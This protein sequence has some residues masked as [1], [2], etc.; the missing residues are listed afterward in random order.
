MENVNYGYNEIQPVVPINKGGR[1]SANK[2]NN[3]KKKA[4]AYNLYC[5]NISQKSIGKQLGIGEKTIGNW[6]KLWKQSQSIEIDTLANLKSR[7]LTMSN[8]STTPI[9]DIKNLVSIIQ[10]LED[11]GSLYIKESLKQQ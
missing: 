4:L 8:D 11:K 1:G 7:L 3:Q 6:A 5:R 10:I 2:F 9:V